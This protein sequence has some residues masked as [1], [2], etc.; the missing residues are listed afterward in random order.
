MLTPPLR[1]GLLAGI[2]RQLVLEMCED[3]RIP[4]E[5][6]TL[7]DAELFEADEAF[8]TSSTREIVPIVRVDGK[9][10]GTGRPARSP[11]DCARRSGRG[12]KH[13]HVGPSFSSGY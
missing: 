4:S 11:H 12:W 1:A 6:R 2:T 7:H 9:A 5:E 10:I 13:R 3:E 8:L